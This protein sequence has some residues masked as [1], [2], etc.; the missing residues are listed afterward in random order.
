VAPNLIVRQRQNAAAARAQGIEVEGLRRFGRWR[1][2]AAYLLADSRFSGGERVPQVA[3]HQGS[4]QV[5]YDRGGTLVSAGLR[6][7]TDQF[8]DE[9]NQFRLPGFATVQL[10]ARRRLT[11]GVSALIAVENLL[12]REYLT[13]F[14]PTPGIGAPRLWRLGLRWESRAP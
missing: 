4:A 2:E 12:D 9:R 11:R 5:V 14:S 8:E 10:L 13:G 6:S 3:R 1:A 7:Y